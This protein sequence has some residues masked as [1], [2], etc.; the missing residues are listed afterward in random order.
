MSNVLF[1]C[2]CCVCQSGVFKYL[3]H[4]ARETGGEMEPTDLKLSTGDGRLPFEC[5]SQGLVHH[6]PVITPPPMLD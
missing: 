1:V 5:V 2:V 3:E 6:I 4:V